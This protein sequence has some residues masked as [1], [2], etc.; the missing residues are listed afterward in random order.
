[1]A[2]VCDQLNGN[3]QDKTPG[4]KGTQ[5]APTLSGAQLERVRTD[6]KQ[7]VREKQTTAVANGLHN[8]QQEDSYAES[9]RMPHFGMP[10]KER[11]LFLACCTT[12]QV[13]EA[14]Q[15]WRLNHK[16]HVFGIHLRWRR[17]VRFPD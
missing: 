15:F 14:T 7:N 13:F 6:C 16:R 2:G 11:V 8:P 17:S 12:T 5:E 3:A 1:M 10:A 4:G 9:L